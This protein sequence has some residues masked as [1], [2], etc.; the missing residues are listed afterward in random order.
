MANY[1]VNWRLRGAK[2]ITEAGAIVKLDD[3]KA[4]RLLKS[5]VVSKCEDEGPVEQAEK[6]NS[7]AADLS[8]MTKAQLVEYGKKEFN[9]DLDINKTRADLTVAIADAASK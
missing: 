1:K 6:S 4:A 5:G 3:A 9:L 7:P 8:A 2:G